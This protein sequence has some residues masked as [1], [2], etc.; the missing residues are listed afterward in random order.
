[1]VFKRVQKYRFP[2]FRRKPE[3]SLFRQLQIIWTPGFTGVTTF[4]EAISIKHCL[5]W[6]IVYV[7]AFWGGEDKHLIWHI[8]INLDI[9]KG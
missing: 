3:S 4:Y 8:I 6:N 1:M 7:C 9:S 2:S 5:L